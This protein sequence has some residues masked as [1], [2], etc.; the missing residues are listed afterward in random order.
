M[1]VKSGL[2][3][4]L[5]QIPPPKNTLLVYCPLTTTMSSPVSMTQSF[6]A[7]DVKVH[8]IAM[9]KSTECTAKAVREEN[10]SVSSGDS[11]MDESSSTDSE[12]SSA[13]SVELDNQEF[14]DSI[15]FDEWDTGFDQC[16][17]SLVPTYSPTPIAVVLSPT[18]DEVYSWSISQPAVYEMYQVR[19]PGGH[20]I[21]GSIKSNVPSPTNHPSSWSNSSRL[22]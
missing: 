6:Y 3:P 21:Q 9:I 15:D 18:G 5:N 19:P 22:N 17:E 8:A 10:N 2:R 11:S 1:S 12:S 14:I 13:S 4:D 16:D 20:F 7:N